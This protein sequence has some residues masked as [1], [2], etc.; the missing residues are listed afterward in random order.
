MRQHGFFVWRLLSLPTH[1]PSLMTTT[2]HHVVQ[3]LDS[4]TS[5]R[6][7]A[8]VERPPDTQTYNTLKAALLKAFVSTQLQ[9]DTALL[10]MQ[11]L[12]DKRPSELLQY[13]QTMNSN[14]ETLFR[15]LF[16]N[17][18]PPEVRK[19]LAQS[20]NEDLEIL[21]EKADHILEVD[22][23]TPAFVAAASNRPSKNFSSTASN[24][25]T[26]CKYHARFGI[27]ARRCE[28][29]VGGRPCAMAPQQ[30]KWKRDQKQAANINTTKSQNVHT[31]PSGNISTITVADVL[32][33]RSFLV[34]TGAEESVFPAS[35]AERKKVRGPSL[36]AANGSAIPTYGK[37]NITLQLG[38]GASFVQNV[39]IADVTQPI[40]GA[41]FFTTQRLA[42]DLTNKRL[43]SLDGG[44]VI[45]GRPA[46][47]QAGRGI[48]KIHSRYE[49]IVEEFPELLVPSFTK[50]K[51]GVLHYIPT[52]GPPVHARAR[53]LD[54]EKLTAAKAEFD[55]MEHL[56][57]VRR[58]S[59]PWSSPLHMVKN[60]NGSWRPCG[61]YRRLNDITRDDRYPLPHIQDLNANLAGKTI[62]F[63]N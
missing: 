12:G 10:Q 32:S 44:L 4:D 24:P 62:F 46:H 36:V 30:P 49:A 5:R 61:D 33:G 43:V 14:P 34:D 59:S 40:L 42:I 63:Q 19:I 51:H 57:I 50:N 26:L 1:L 29:K 28:N 47:L 17:Q 9:K 15:A 6:V 41:D 56:G 39:W 23:P 60:S 16:L 25:F 35:I 54:H 2:F 31:A 38:K 7:Q 52:T 8:V 18:L 21:A 3:L 53:R 20:P 27:E 48:H 22:F 45:P 37:R 58:S 11:G 13:M 55:E